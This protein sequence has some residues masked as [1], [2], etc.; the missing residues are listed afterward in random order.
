[1][2]ED[3]IAAYLKQLGKQHFP[4][5]I[6]T[7]LHQNAS[8]TLTYRFLL[9]DEYIEGRE[10]EFAMLVATFVLIIMIVLVLNLALKDVIG[11][12]GEIR[13][14]TGEMAEKK[15]LGSLSLSKHPDNEI[16]E[17]VDNINKIKKG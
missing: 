12:L 11:P 4:E 5:E 17:I 2:E 9:D 10:D 1:M 3:Q 13:A 14:Q 16:G 8:G 15:E 7:I 6:L